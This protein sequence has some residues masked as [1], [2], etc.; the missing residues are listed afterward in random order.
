MTGSAYAYSQASGRCASMQPN[1]L[2]ESSATLGWT[3]LLLD[4]HEGSGHSDAF[5]THPTDDLTLVVATAGR[6]ELQ[7]LAGGRWRTALYQPGNA[8][9]T[10]PGE[11]ARLR[12]STP[13][14]RHAFGTL[15]LYLPGS[16]LAQI[17]DEYR[18]SG[19]SAD[20]DQLS[21]LTFRDD[22]VTAHA[23]ALLA[24]H[25][26]GEPDL[27]AAGAARWLTT[28]L[29]SRQAQWRN[30][31]DDTRQPAALSDR[32]LAR[33]IEFMSCHLDRALTL[34][35]LA[36][37]AGISVHHFG[38]RFREHVGM[39]PAAYLTTLRIDRACL[40]L[41]T[42]DLAVSEIA[43]RCGY[44]RASGFSTAFLRHRGCTPSAFRA[45]R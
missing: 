22:I 4:R 18:R 35:E 34:D 45:G 43:F 44:P 9:M 12:W 1:R 8:G 39:G 38:R 27:Y 37:E 25:R 6:H 20:I 33:V 13:S 17:A 23:N 32:R 28:H 21:V 7:A 5:E 40:L 15:H 24:A 11:T 41:R 36:R 30:V 29:L 3:S 31:A 19:Q 10:P 2:I 14:E 26:S 42:T 16:L